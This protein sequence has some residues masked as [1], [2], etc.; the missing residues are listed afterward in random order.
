[1]H[2]R[3]VLSLIGAVGLSMSVSMSGCL[4]SEPGDAE[5]KEAN[6]SSPESAKNPRLIEQSNGDFNYLLGKQRICPLGQY[7]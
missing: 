7:L 3:R 6:A 5:S 2:R 1:M 4:S